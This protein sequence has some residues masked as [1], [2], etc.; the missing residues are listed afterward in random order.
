MQLNLSPA[1][2]RFLVCLTSSF[3][4]QYQ[5]LFVC[6]E[7]KQRDIMPEPLLSEFLNRH[8]N[9]CEITK[10]L[11]GDPLSTS[12]SRIVGL[13]CNETV[14]IETGTPAVD[15]FRVTHIGTHRVWEQMEPLNLFNVIFPTL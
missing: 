9:P 6:W 10:R 7:D 14:N 11:T 12:Y 4:T 8:M 15:E 5:G 1:P 3:S 13:I 2:S